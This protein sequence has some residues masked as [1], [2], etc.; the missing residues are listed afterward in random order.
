M[1]DVE[2]L[3]ARPDEV[4]PPLQPTPMPPTGT[5][6]PSA[7][8]ASAVPPAS[9]GTA[10]PPSAPTPTVRRTPVPPK[11]KQ[12]E[13]LGTLGRKKRSSAYTPEELEIAIDQEKYAFSNFLEDFRDNF[14]H[15]DVDTLLLDIKANH[16]SLLKPANSARKI[17]DIIQLRDNMESLGVCKA[18][19]SY[20]V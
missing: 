8:E 7:P 5:Q 3:E 12:Q 6:P 11:S 18:D 16:E 1:E 14:D 10:P 20:R 15:K 9:G 17:D 2:I 19:L 13:L 4:L